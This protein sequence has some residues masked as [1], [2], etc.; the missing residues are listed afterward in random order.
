MKSNLLQAHLTT[1]FNGVAPE[2]LYEVYVNA[3]EHTRATGQ[4][5]AIDAKEGGA[6]SAYGGYLTGTFIRLRPGQLV[7]QF[8]RSR[9][10]N[11]TDPDAVLSIAFRRNDYEQVEA[12]LLLTNVRNDMTRYDNSSWNQFYWEPFREYLRGALQPADFAQ[13]LSQPRR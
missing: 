1:Q 3:E 6:F 5:A 4:P 9:H 10:F 2:R 13:A 12:E 7:V 8:W 11:D